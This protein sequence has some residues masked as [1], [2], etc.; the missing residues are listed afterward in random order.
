M[1]LPESFLQELKAR[2]DLAEIAAN[3]VSLKRSGRN[4]VG[5]CPFHSEKSPSFNI[6]PENGSFYC[7]GCGT[8]GDVITFIRRIENLDYMEAVRFLAQRAGLQVPEAQVDDGMAKLRAR[9]LEINRET[10][11]FFYSVLNSDAGREGR[12]Y[13]NRREL[14]QETVRHF[15]L[16]YSP[17]S[18][19][20]LVDMLEKKGYTQNEMILANVAFKSR[21]GR[22]V[23]RFFGRVM[24]PII[25]LRGNV[26]AFGGRT[27]GDDKPKYLNTS[28]TPV[29]NKGNLLFA[30]N[31]AKNCN[32]ER[33]ILCEGYM[34][35]IALHQA[36]FQEAVATLGTSLTAPQARLMARYAKEIVVCY[37]S[38]EPGQKAA[39]RAIPILRD[40]GLVVR[41]LTVTGGKDPDEYIKTNGPIKFKQLLDACGNDVEYR[42]QKAKQGRNLQ[43]PEQ[44]VEYLNAAAS[45]LATLENRIEQE[46]YA[47]RLAQEAGIATAT[48]MNQISAYSKRNRKKQMKKQ[49]Q[50][51]QQQAAGLRDRVNPEKAGN[52]RAAV[53]EEALIAHLLKF[54]ESSEKIAAILPPEKFITSFNRR[55]YAVIV[56][57]ITKGNAVGLADLSEEF[58]MDEISSVSRILAAQ[59]GI[60]LTWPDVLEYINIISQEND[61]L[62]ISRAESVR[63]EEIED[64]LKKLRQQKK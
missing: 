6:Y 43:I 33:L 31:F 29:F 40:A 23:D 14:K 30:L 36:G 15:G 3:Y 49:F 61:K 12:E 1:P 32:S 44:R 25:D 39:S 38:D 4:L 9:I 63:A 46:V 22:A 17:A 10:A 48:V 19:F 50:A 42:L 47:G 21:S 62:T 35:V 60:T 24:F 7:F 2:C 57:R 56:G 55:V 13:F 53:A 52:L 8:G 37:D 34:D 58:T 5:L 16:G 45:V 28:E 59:D 18:R 51:V 11:R 26:V 20:A 27:L 41:V 64:Y 54:P